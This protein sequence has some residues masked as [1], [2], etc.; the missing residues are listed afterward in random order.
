MPAEADRLV[1]GPVVGTLLVQGDV[2][3]PGEA[4]GGL[5][6]GR[7]ESG[8]LVGRGQPPDAGMALIAKR[9]NLVRGRPPVSRQLHECDA[10]P[11]ARA[12]TD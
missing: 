8:H 10:S 3:V 7:G 12:V 5:A 9:G 4:V 6:D 2:A 1:K 11:V